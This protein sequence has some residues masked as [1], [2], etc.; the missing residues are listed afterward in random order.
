MRGG[1]ARQFRRKRVKP[2][3]GRR[4][5]QFLDAGARDTR[6]TVALA[7]EALNRR[8]D[9]AESSVHDAR[10]R[11]R[12]SQDA[13]GLGHTGHE[14]PAAFAFGKQLAAQLKMPHRTV[15]IFTNFEKATI[16]L[17]FPKTFLPSHRQRTDLAAGVPA[18]AAL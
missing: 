5:H 12:E 17:P 9:L 18:D 14:K 11:R 16:L 10:V 2:V 3:A 6:W 7:N 13:A 15:L 8:H 1:I 4:L